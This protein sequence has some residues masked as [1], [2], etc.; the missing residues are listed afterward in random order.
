MG[1]DEGGLHVRH[2]LDRAAVLVDDRHLR[3]RALGEL[4]D[5]PLHDLGALEDV[6]VLE[7]V[8]L[9][10]EDLLDAQRP[11]LV[12]R[13]R[14]PERL[15]P[16]RQLDRPRAGVA[17]ERHGERLEHDALDVVLRLGLGQAERVDLHPVAKAQ[18]LGILHAIALA[19]DLLPQLRHRAQLGVLL[20]EA[21]AGIDEERDAREDPAHERFV[22]ALA[23]RIEH[24]DRVAERVGDL[25]YRRRA[26]LLQVVGADVDRV[27]ARD[28]CH[29]V[30][31]HVGGQPH[32]RCGRERIGAA[33][34]EL[35]DDVVLRRALQDRLVH[36][37]LLGGDD[38]ER[39]Q[40]GRRRVDRHRRVHRLQRDAVH[41]LRHRC[42]V[43]DRHADLAD[44]AAR[45][46]VIGVVARLGRQVEGDRQP[47]LALREVRAVQGV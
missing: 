43:A 39:Q 34:E 10:G 42:A 18:L 2:R 4:G 12:P 16:R 33:R 1:L 32:R 40:P 26:R 46:L 3:P 38:V 47:R 35:L 24:R 7:Q 28:L 8:G 29:R 37:V 45:E 11:L 25:L 31:D 5:E 44:L 41:Q 14:Q 30:G 6:G 15:V 27:P 9:E 13:P 22:D 21:H 36:A 19:A 23:D 17:A 20:D